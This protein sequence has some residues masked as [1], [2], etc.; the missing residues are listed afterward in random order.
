M[1]AFVVGLV[2][3]LAMASHSDAAYCV[4]NSNVNETVLQKN[5]D[6][7]CGAGAD[8]KSI[9]QNE[10][11]YNPNT[12]RDHCNYAVNSYFQKKGQVTGSC[13]FQGTAMVTQT[14]P[15]AA[16]GCQYLS[17]PGGGGIS[18][19][20]GATTVEGSNSLGPT[21]SGFDNSAGVTQKTSQNSIFMMLILCLFPY[22]F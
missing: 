3:F 14:A 7:A 22:L 12:V 10:A 5:I 11:C 9:H 1:A 21:G 17:S 19:G 18:T 4:C 15:T 6:Y 8:C 20:G 13:D 16:S 2:L